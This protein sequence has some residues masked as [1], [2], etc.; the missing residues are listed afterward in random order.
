VRLLAALLCL[1]SAGAFAQAWPA[2][3]IRIVVPLPAGGS[4]D[5]IARQFAQKYSE[6]WSRPVIVDNRPGAGTN[7]GAEIVAKAPPDGY[8]WLMNSTAQAISAALYKNLAY[9][10]EKDLA[11]VT[12]LMTN[13]LVF[14]VP[15]KLPQQTLKEMMAAMKAEPG[16]VAFG[17]TG[18]GSGGHLAIEMFLQMAGL[19]A[20]HVP[21]KG[22]AGLFPGLVA[23]DVSFALAPSQ[24][25][26]SHVRGGRVRALAVA[27]ARR[28][29]ALPDVPTMAEASGLNYQYVGWTSVFTT[30]GTPREVLLRIS[31]E[32]GRI[33]RSPEVQKSFETWGV[34][35]YEMS[36]DEFTARYRS[37]IAAFRKVVR[38]AGIKVE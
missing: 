27:A 12:P 32:S 25:A 34:E 3:N 10:P 35:P 18:I 28:T 11:P 30:A 14:V 9:D 5:G 16:K 17:T 33:V 1:V 4:I 2:K 6:A 20:L 29:R 24:S 22:D 38:D 26:V 15:A 19:K 21:Y 7:I 13:I 36:V 8:T 37:D 23:A 31:E